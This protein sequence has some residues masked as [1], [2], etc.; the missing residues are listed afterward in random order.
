MGDEE[1]E[2]PSIK[3]QHAFLDAG[4]RKDWTSV[5]TSLAVSP[6]LI[7]VQPLGRWSVL[8]QAAEQGKIEVV[9]F[10]LERRADTSA[11]T[12][13]GKTP[14]EVSSTDAVRLLLSAVEPACVTAVTGIG[15]TAAAAAG[16]GPS[17]TRIAPAASV[18]PSGTRSDSA[19]S[20]TPDEGKTSTTVWQ[21]QPA[22]LPGAWVDVGKERQALF[23]DAQAAGILKAMFRESGRSYIVDLEMLTQT[24]FLSGEV[25]P[26]R[27]QKL[28]DLALGAASSAAETRKVNGGSVASEATDAKVEA[29]AFDKAPEAE[30]TPGQTVEVAGSGAKP[31]IVKNCGGGVWSCT[32]ISWR[33][34][35]KKPTNQ[36]SC[37]HIVSI[38]GDAAEKKR[39]AEV[40][41]TSDAAAASV[42]TPQMRT[43]VLALS[44]S[45]KS[46]GGK[47]PP[48]LLLA[49]AWE[50]HVEPKGWWISEKLDGMRAFW[51]PAKRCLVSR[52]GNEYCAPSIFWNACPMLHLM[53][54][55]SSAV[56]ASK[57]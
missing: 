52:L 56:D 38:R 2:V 44:S 35:G 57:S 41:S 45:S 47:T 13:D 48:A 3:Q 9:S 25:R 17:D 49:K 8:H 55:S 14:L 50:E 23:I 16:M 37:K 30:L 36:R 20:V 51:D 46:E 19:A 43:P 7:N 32:C 29:P 5:K 26:I 15:R 1:G 33:M 4:K 54:N 31:Y 27:L 21:V 34:Q 10:L 53:V 6:A 28:P 12:K 11:T 22:A 39:L 24:D 18:G 42:P 40:T